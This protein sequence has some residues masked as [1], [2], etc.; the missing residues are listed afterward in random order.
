VKDVELHVDQQ[1]GSSFFD[2]CKDVKFAATNGF[3]MDFM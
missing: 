1:F 3:A 2:A